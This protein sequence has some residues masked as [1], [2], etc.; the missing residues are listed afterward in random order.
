MTSLA[1]LREKRITVIG[2]G[3]SGRGLASL[4]LRQG[5]RV[6]VSEKKNLSEE[7]RAFFSRRGI[8]WEEG[9]H[10]EAAFNAHAMVI[11]SGI[12]PT[13]PVVKKAQERGV[14][15]LGELD[16]VAPFLRGR[17]IGVTGSNGKSTTVS[18]LGHFLSKAG[19]KVSVSGNIGASLAD[20]AGEDWDFIV[21]E[22]SS[23][24]LF[25]NNLLACDGAIVTN[26]AP[27]HIDWH[28][29]FE[30]YIR[31]KSRLLSTMKKDGFAIIQGRDE[32]LLGKKVS[33]ENLWRFSWNCEDLHGEGGRVI[34]SPRGRSVYFSR[35][36]VRERLFGF[37]DLPLLGR[38]N[39][40]NAAMA[41]GAF[42]IL[43][44]RKSPSDNFY[45]F[46][47]LPHRCEKVARI[48]GLLFVDD[49][50]GTNV[51]STSASLAAIEGP[52]V[53]IL[54]GQGKGEDYGPL[55]RAVREEAAAAV[56]MGEEAPK[57]LAALKEAGFENV[58]EARGMEDAVAKAV[59]AAPENGTVLLSPACTSWDQYPDFKKRGEHFKAVVKNL[60]KKP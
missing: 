38:H 13:A 2:G 44:G 5:A 16:F 56:V 26:L 21:A 33:E 15:V 34:A 60:E 22:L 28:G 46:T 39:V 8:S 31:A 1:D 29:S 11:G 14:T 36:S 55:A 41:A 35:N 43:N 51:A 37:A 3:V 6:F 54:G 20:A 9:G 17:I 42:R 24:Q 53:I 45:D 47:G 49:S 57:I 18:L 12:P 10:S 59:A 40:E 58:A 50:K 48:G 7:G 19:F 52:K 23:F 32:D 25:W 27:D 30:E 4:A